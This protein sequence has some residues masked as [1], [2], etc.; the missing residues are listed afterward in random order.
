MHQRYRARAHECPAGGERS[1]TT[2]SLLLALAQ[3]CEFPFHC[4]DE[5]DVSVRRCVCV[6]HSSWSWQPFQQAWMPSSPASHVPTP[7]CP[8]L[9]LTQRMNAGQ[10]FM[11]AVIRRVATDMLLS[12]AVEQKTRQ[13]ILLTP[14]VRR[15]RTSRAPGQGRAAHASLALLSSIM[16]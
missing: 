7:P 16:R 12:F 14:Q 9:P 8:S 6:W 11:D 15:L 2:V 4:L 10:V 3:F 5:Y 13:V 1:Y